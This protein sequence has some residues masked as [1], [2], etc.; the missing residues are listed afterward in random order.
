MF[1]A[2]VRY[3]DAAMA[4]L[5]REDVLRIAGLARLRLE[6]RELQLLTRDLAR[7]LDYFS[8]L[9]RI[10]VETVPPTAHPLDATGAGRD[11]TPGACLDHDRAL[12]AAPD[13]AEGYF[14]VPRVL[15]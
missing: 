14:R 11:D 8:A 3:A 2:P 9:Q 5:T 15:D 4:E 12:A 13:A 1:R 10:D 7:I 6:D